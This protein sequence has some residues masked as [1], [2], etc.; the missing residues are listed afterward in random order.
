[1]ITEKD[2]K[3]LNFNN[4]QKRSKEI[5]KYSGKLPILI[6]NYINMSNHEKHITKK[7]LDSYNAEREMYIKLT[8]DETYEYEIN[9]LI[10]WINKNPQFTD[11]L[12][13]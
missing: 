13:L 4:I 5:E 10:K 3:G 1:M 2:I 7:T 6:Y 11:L 12:I 9:E 8:D